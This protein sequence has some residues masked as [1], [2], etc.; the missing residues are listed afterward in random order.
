MTRRYLLDT[1]TVS[2]TMARVP[3]RGV[4]QKMSQHGLHCALP[5]PVWHELV[6]GCERLSPGQRRSTLEAY[7]EDV[8]RKSFVVLDYDGA[9]AEWHAR[10]RARLEAAG[11][12]APFVDGQIASIARV[13]DLVLVTANPKDFRG[14]AGLTIENWVTK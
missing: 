11:K 14:F 13:H 7:L 8:V 5:A 10:E 9:A 2:W 3:N 1:S 6:Y 4:V 12:P